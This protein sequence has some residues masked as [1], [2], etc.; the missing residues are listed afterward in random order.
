MVVCFACGSVHSLT[1]A[2]EAMKQQLQ[3]LQNDSTSET[4]K[5]RQTSETVKR[6]SRKL[7]LV[8]KVIV[9]VSVSVYCCC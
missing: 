5:Q 4:D 1:A 3:K 7:L 6:L 8:S 2:S 9:S